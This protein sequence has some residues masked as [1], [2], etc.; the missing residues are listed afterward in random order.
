MTTPKRLRT[1]AR[2]VLTVTLGLLVGV[3]LL[4][5][6]GG[7]QGGYNSYSGNS[8]YDGKFT[9]VR[10]SY[11]E[12]GF[13]RGAPM[14]SHDYP[15]GEEHFMK[16][17][18]ALTLVPLHVE[19][20]NIMSLGDPEIF[21][22]PVIYMCE[23]GTWNMSDAEALSLRAFLQKGGFMIIDDMGSAASRSRRGD[24]WP[25]FEFQMSRVFPTGRWEDIPADHPIFHS[26]YDIWKPSDIPQYYDTGQPMFRGLYEDNDH[27]KRL[28]VFVNYNTDI[29]EFWEWSDTGIKPM[30][31]SNEAYKL[32]VNEF[33]YGIIH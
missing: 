10:V 12:N 25:N 9:F 21:K 24:Q 20:H 16:I 29:S 19:E 2:S 13:G 27:S 30:D 7:Y 26:F 18:N 3:T 32:G 15:K 28:M 14:W 8:K 33:M 5:Q 31:E 17:M 11:T 23:P 1:L 22:F 6:R 4:A